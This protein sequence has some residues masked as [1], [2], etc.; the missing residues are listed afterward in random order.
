MESGNAIALHDGSVIRLGD[1]IG[2]FR[3]EPR[4]ATERENDAFP[5][6]S[7]LARQV[8]MRLGKLALAS[9]HTLV[10]G[11]T[12]TGTER[13]ARARGAT[14]GPFVPQNCAELSRELARSELFGHL[15]GAFSGAATAR[16]GLV[17][18]AD[19]GVL[20]LDEIGELALDVQGDLLRFLEDG[21]YRPIGST[22]LRRSTARIV[23]ATNV[24]LD[25]AVRRGVIRRDLMARLRASNAT[26]HLP[27][28]RD[29]REDI[30]GWADR[31]LREAGAVPPRAWN[32]GAAECLLLYP[33]PENLRELRGVI[34]GLVADEPRWPASS[35]A[36][37]ERIQAYRRTLRPEPQAEP[38]PPPSP[39]TAPARGATEPT[40]EQIIDALARMRGRMRNVSEL[41]RVERR[42]LYRLCRQYGI[43]FESYRGRSQQEG[44]T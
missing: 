22:E 13:V 27:P 35:S 42:K 43:D 38:P 16:P 7:P 2:V 11:E 4:A 8:R 19:G 1:S 28:L 9:G 29:R 34:R 10:L 33:W 17:E 15:R 20:F 6:A 41:L 30:L 26:L 18:I 44:S 14:A 39:A 36:L 37:P 5:G 24:D 31:F 25:D 32:G 40:R 23:A 3:T 21:S 12:G